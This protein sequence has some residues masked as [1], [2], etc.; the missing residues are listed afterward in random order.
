[1]MRQLALFAVA[2][3]VAFAISGAPTDRDSS[4]PQRLSDA[5]LPHNLLPLVPLAQSARWRAHDEAA[6]PFNVRVHSDATGQLQNEQQIGVNPTD[7]DNLV[8]VWR[9]FRLGYRQVGLG[10]SVDGGAS[11]TDALAGNTPFAW[12][13]DPGLA[14]DAAGRAYAV[15]LSY[16]SAGDG[17]GLYVLRSDD[18][19]STWQGP[20]I[21]T[22]NY[23]YRL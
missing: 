21:V 15:I 23:D 14:W 2:L 1:M 19:G 10:H 3:G 20:G 9:D 13:S 18:G 5:G 7:P 4:A 17:D 22:E 8:A 11:W 6:N 16:E 12:D